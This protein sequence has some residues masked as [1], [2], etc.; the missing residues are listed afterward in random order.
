MPRTR[1]FTPP[2]PQPC[3]SWSE[4][5]RGCLE[6]CGHRASAAATAGSVRSP[7]RAGRRLSARHP[8]RCVRR[9]NRDCVEPP[10]RNAQSLVEPPELRHSPRV[11]VGV[12]EI[13]L[14]PDCA[15][16][17]RRLLRPTGFRQDAPQVV[18]LR[19]IGVEPEAS[20]N[21]SI[22]SGADVPAPAPSP[23]RCCIRPA[24][25]PHSLLKCPMARQ[26]AGLE[27]GSGEV[28]VDFRIVGPELQSAFEVL[29]ASCGCLLRQRETKCCA[30]MEGWI[31]CQ[32]GERCDSVSIGAAVLP[33]QQCGALPAWPLRSGSSAQSRAR[34][35]A[36][37]PSPLPPPQC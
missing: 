34:A 14:R 32:R 35:A 37:C 13:G 25:E 27:Q 9:G 33:R 28:V 11:G 12:R 3:A 8:G 6:H 36:R 26:A 17:A 18:L 5:P 15:G 20:W 21:C 4:L 1:Q 2:A 16:N 10:A 24:V 22:T 23:A 29:H 31:L 19:Q 30:R 7:R